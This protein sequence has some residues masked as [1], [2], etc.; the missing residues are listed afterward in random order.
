MSNEI[1]LLNQ[2]GK[3]DVSEEEILIY[4]RHGD[5]N[6]ENGVYYFSG[7]QIKITFNKSGRFKEIRGSQNSIFV[8]RALSDLRE[9]SESKENEIGYFIVNGIRPLNSLFKHREQLQIFPLPQKPKYIIG[10][11]SNFAYPFIVEFKY[12]S[13]IVD[14]KP[15]S[16]WGIRNYRRS[17]MHQ[18]ILLILNLL[19]Y[20]GIEDVNGTMNQ[21]SWVQV[22]KEWREATD[23]EKEM[24]IECDSPMNSFDTEN[25]YLN[26]FFKPNGYELDTTTFTKVTG[27]VNAPLVDSNKYFQKLGKT[28][29]EFIDLPAN[30]GVC[31][32]KYFTIQDKSKLNRS[33]YW[34]KK[35]SEAWEISKSISFNCLIQAIEVLTKSENPTEKCQEKGCDNYTY[36]SNFCDSCGKP[37]TIAGPTFA[38]R[39]FIETYAAGIPDNIKKEFYNLRS[40]IAHGSL[41]MEM[42]KNSGNF[43]A[44]SH[45]Q[46]NLYDSAKSV[47][48]VSLVNWL[49]SKE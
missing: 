13:C 47:V 36:K 3:L 29:D 11:R 21:Y 24:L 26:R 39:E 4:L 35:S 34:Y 48:T 6:A 1:N 32:D 2:F 20:G 38:F 19:I 30:I 8:K 40:S 45:Q 44:K 5:A 41:L 42:D 23:E 22:P 17:E 33:L 28:V 43:D 14:N 18:N 16:F 12:Q 46:R 27:L 49:L 37:V 10:A 9:I 15:P 25:M 7:N 31:L